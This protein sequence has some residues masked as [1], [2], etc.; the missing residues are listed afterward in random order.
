MRYYESPVEF[1]GTDQVEAVKIVRNVLVRRDNGSLASKPTDESFI[2]PVDVVFRSI[3]YMITPTPG[4]PYDADW[5]WIPNEKGRVQTERNGPPVQ[6]LYIA[7]WAKRGPSGVIGTNKPDAIE[8]V[9][10]LLEDGA[11][12]RL[13]EP[14]GEDITRPTECPRCP[15]RDLR[16]VEG[17]GSAGDGGRR[18][19]RAGR[20]SSS[21]TCRTCWRPL[22]ASRHARRQT[23]GGSGGLLSEEMWGEVR[24]SDLPL[25]LR[26]VA[27]WPPVRA[28]YRGSATRSASGIRS[29][30]R[31]ARHG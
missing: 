5:R 20:G 29:A 22:R 12:G 16:P 30:W 7:G 15:L 11:A 26:L 3:G 25:A 21:W 2:L 27:I 28:P 24:H 13:K 6:G 9:A 31:T 10:M 8:T 18:R 19:P 4:V 1:I 14:S 23:S 17:P